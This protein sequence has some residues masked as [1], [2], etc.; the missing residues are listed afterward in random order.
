MGRRDR[1]GR[2]PAADGPVRLTS[3]D[4]RR[5][6][7]R[8]PTTACP[9]GGSGNQRCAGGPHGSCRRSAPSS[10]LCLPPP[11]CA[12]PSLAAGLDPALR[13]HPLAPAAPSDC[14][15]G[16]RHLRHPAGHGLRGSSLG[17][18][19]ALQRGAAPV[20]KPVSAACRTGPSRR[21]GKRDHGQSPGVATALPPCPWPASP[22]GVA[23]GV[24][25]GAVALGRPA[26]QPQVGL[27]SGAG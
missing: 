27:G 11:F 20:G 4:P 21:I 3:E 12:A 13:R 25:A 1:H 8:H 9:G 7:W 17:K 15:G 14:S 5:H 2:H 23:D 16:G 24:V 10:R 18:R 26:Q 6:G 22:G 19:F